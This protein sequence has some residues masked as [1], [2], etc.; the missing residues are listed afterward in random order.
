MDETKQQV[1][2]AE[3]DID[4][5]CN[6]VK[7]TFKLMREKLDEE[8]KTILSK[9]Q[10]AR[11]LVKKTGEVTAD[12]QKMTLASLESLNSCQEKLVDKGSDYDYVTVTVSLQRDV[13]N[14]FCGELP[15]FEWNSEILKKGKIESNYSGR[16]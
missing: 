11:K 3:A 6:N 13:E 15:G 8:E 14:H 7:S 12:S 10:E 5:A 4:D 16:V 2:Q 1:E 9:M